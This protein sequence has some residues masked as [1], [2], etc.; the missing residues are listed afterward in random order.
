MIAEPARL[1][2]RPHDKHGRPVPWFAIYTEDGGYDFRVADGGALY[3]ALKYG[4]C[5]V[6]GMPFLRQE[7]RAFVVG[8]M[9]A[10]NRTSAE[11]PSHEDCGIYSARAC[12]FLNT[13]KMVRRERHLPGGVEDPG[14]F[15]IMR[16][17]GVAMVW[18]VRY[19]DWRKE[20]DNSARGKFVFRFGDPLRVTW[21]CQGREATRAEVQESID[22]GL[23][24]LAEV[25]EAEGE[26][27]VADLAA[28]VAAVGRLL[29]AA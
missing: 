1:Q 20:G 19:R 14:G 2:R 7:P 25:A 18:T 5:W 11:P 21:W 16:N 12:P 13:P 28:E 24:A 4:L 15:M 29:P 17:P 3:A 10:V 22:S 23:P 26:A 27:A 8:P 9:C 6:C